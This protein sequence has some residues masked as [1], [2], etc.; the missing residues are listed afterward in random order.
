MINLD[1]SVVSILTIH[2]RKENLK[3]L[4]IRDTYNNFVAFNKKFLK[5]N[6]HIS[7]RKSN[8]MVRQ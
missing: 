1:H 8:F 5:K 6:G 2:F 4:H 7:C 3:C